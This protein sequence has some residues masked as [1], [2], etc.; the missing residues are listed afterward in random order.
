VW[1][2][3]LSADLVTQ[4]LLRQHGYQVVRHSF[5]MRLEMRA[6]P[7][8]PTMPENIT[9]RPLKRHLEE[10][11]AVETIR[12]VF[13]DEP[14]W[15]ERPLE[16]ELDDWTHYFNHAPHADPSLWFVASEGNTI[17]GTCFGHPVLPEDPDMGYVFALGVRRA[18]RR[19]GIALAL[20][21]QTFRALY[22]RGKHKV[23]L[24]VDAENPTGATRLYE[25]TGMRVVRRFDVFEKMVRPANGSS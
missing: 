12:E 9:I 5:Q 11:A 3:V 1:Q 25:K 4:Q 23:Q 6:P 2:E 24:G 15:V 17:V 7:P 8:K 19:R 20:L 14:G 10:R 18:W 22:H 16:E 21:C 13:K